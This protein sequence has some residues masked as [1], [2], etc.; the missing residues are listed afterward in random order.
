MDVDPTVN[1]ILDFFVPDA[2]KND[3]QR[4]APIY[5]EPERRLRLG[6]EGHQFCFEIEAWNRE[7][8]RCVVRCVSSN[9]PSAVAINDR[10]NLTWA[11]LRISE[12][13]TP[14]FPG[15]H[16]RLLASFDNAAA[17]RENEWW[18]WVENAA[19]ELGVDLALPPM[20]P[21]LMLG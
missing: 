20:A 1:S 19:V 8:S 18:E 14:G 3:W 4:W 7:I 5:V 10:C 13:G 16:T 6:Y 12:H 15:Y 9:L 11:F 17:V 21:Q 2:C